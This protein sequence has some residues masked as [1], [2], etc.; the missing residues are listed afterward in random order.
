MAVLKPGQRN[1][2]QLMCVLPAV[3]IVILGASCGS[4]GDDSLSGT[5]AVKYVDTLFLCEY[6]FYRLESQ[7]GVVFTLLSEKHSGERLTAKDSEYETIR[8]GKTYDLTLTE[9][10]SLLIIKQCF[11]RSYI[12]G[13]LVF[14]EYHGERSPSDTG[15]VFWRLDTI[16]TKA[17]WSPQVYDKYY[18]GQEH[19]VPGD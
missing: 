13:F 2:R 11:T 16:C 12:E 19:L 9:F 17:Y 8:D 1:V 18:V 4:T 14:N 5:Y 3:I 7:E 15:I 6:N 10:D